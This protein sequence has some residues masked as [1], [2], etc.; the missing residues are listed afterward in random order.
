[1]KI[2]GVGE[3]A[4]EI[5]VPAGTLGR[6]QPSLRD[7]ADIACALDIITARRLFLMLGQ[8]VVVADG[9]VL[10]VEA[11]EGNRTPCWRALPTCAGEGRL[12]KLAGV[13]VLRQGAETWTGGPSLRP[14]GDWAEDLSKALRA[15]V[16]PGSPSPPAAPLSPSR[17]KWSAVADREKIFFVG[18][19][20]DAAQ[21]SGAQE[22]RPETADKGAA[23]ARFIW[24]P[25]NNPATP[26]ARCG[27]RSRA[28]CQAWA[29]P[30]S[31]PASA[32][33]AWRRWGSK[34]CSRSTASAWIGFSSVLAR[35]PMIMRRICETRRCHRRPRGLD[36]LVIPS[37]V[38][39]SPIALR[40]ACAA[41]APSI[42]NP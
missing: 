34:A 2:I 15:P 41:R 7:D 10:A 30:S 42:P 29:V 6:Y 33:A 18:V 31:S 19:A 36:A 24:S 27:A 32:A 40:A 23:A 3:V 26:S 17:R 4:L 35:L 39:I 1:M 25:P 16:S 21:M 8:A 38:R 9:H 28:Q 37:T 22:P 14:A 20:A 13:R 5:I 12:T 11:A